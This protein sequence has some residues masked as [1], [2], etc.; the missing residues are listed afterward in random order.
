[1]KCKKLLA[2]L[3]AA[4]MLLSGAPVLA[5]ESF[6]DVAAEAFYA[7]A[8]EWAVEKGITNGTG[9]GLFAPLETV[10]RSQA[11]TFLWRMAGQPVPTQTQTFSDVE[12]DPN[13]VWYETAV[14]WA[15]EKGITNGTGDGLFSPTVTCDRGMILTMLYRM[16][17]RP[18][19]EVLATE[20]PENPDDWSLEDLGAILIQSTLKSIREEGHLTDVKEGDYFEIPVLWAL[21]SGV[22]NTAIIGN[23]SP[24]AIQPTT[25]C[26]RGEMV[27]FLQYTAKYEE[28][29]SSAEAYD[30]PVTPIET[31]TVE[32]TTVMDKDGLKVTLK[33]IEI[34]SDDDVWLR[35][36]AQNNSQKTLTVEAQEV[37]VNTFYTVCT[38]FIPVQDEYFTFYED[39]E[40][41]AGES[42]D[43]YVSLDYLRTWNTTA[44]YEIELQMAS[45]VP[46][47]VEDY[48][49]YDEFATGEP[50]TIR[51]SLYDGTQSYDL[52]GVPVLEKDT[53]KVRVYKA[54]NDLFAG[55]Q[56]GVYG[57]NSGTEEACLDLAELKL[58]GEPVE[59]SLLLCMDPGKRD[60]GTVYIDLDYEEDLPAP[61]EAQ[62]TFQTVDPETFDPIQTLDPV[63]VIFAE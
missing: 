11:V 34:G 47:Q 48:Y 39:V 17:G 42:R 30:Q 4:G 24:V 29:I 27:F 21:L 57:Y 7:P 14:Q 36:T 20:L 58:D 50:V 62:L 2:S 35:M 37:Y 63:T 19:D 61:K 41:P 44:V 1:M 31:G 8:V 5:A 16:E 59:A 15:V 33:G 32:E 10:T 55:P 25:P 52:E 40:I 53:L 6:P 9:D 51:T 12:N 49:Q 60:A 26:P 13:K 22:L 56:I 46:T 3:L 45:Y 38:T 54:E 18:F 23:E 43:F 28:D